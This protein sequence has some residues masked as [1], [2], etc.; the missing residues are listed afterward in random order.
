MQIIHNYQNVVLGKIVEEI[1][2]D[3]KE[4]DLIVENISLSSVH[5]QSGANI[6]YAIVVY[7]K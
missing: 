2:R 7:R 4:N 6:H 5:L 1:E 3:C